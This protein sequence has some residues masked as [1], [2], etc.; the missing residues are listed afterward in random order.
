MQGVSGLLP[1][2]S[3]REGDEDDD[4]KTTEHDT[5]KRVERPALAG[6]Q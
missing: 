2:E 1:R 4:G 5:P 3:E 6:W